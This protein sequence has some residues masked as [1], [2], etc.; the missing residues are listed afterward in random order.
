MAWQSPSAMNAGGANGGAD[1]NA[2]A[3][4]EYTLQGR[5]AWGH[6]AHDARQCS[7]AN[8]AAGVMRFLQ[9]E[10]HNHERARNAWD[11]ERAEMKAKIAKQE[12]EVRSAKKLNDQLNK[13]IRM[14]EH[15]LTNERNKNKSGG[16]AQASDDKKDSKG[17]K[18]SLKRALNS[19]TASWVIRTYILTPCSSEQAPQLFPRRRLWKH[20]PTRR[21]PRGLAREVQIVPHEVRRRDYIPP[22]TT[23]ASSATAAWNAWIGQRRRFPEPQ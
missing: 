6:E 9:L 3:G 8:N 7:K 17:K 2:P 13:H 20:R 18:G 19:P 16:E 23:A 21:R 1:G 14:L 5:T 11:I 10:W 4:T 22:D 15:A 12:G